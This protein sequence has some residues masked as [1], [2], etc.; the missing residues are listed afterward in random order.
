MVNQE[1]V[2]VMVKAIQDDDFDVE[3]GE[4]IPTIEL[5]AHSDQTYDEDHTLQNPGDENDT[6]AASSVDQ[7]SRRSLATAAVASPIGGIMSRS[8]QAVEGS[9]PRRRPEFISAA[10]IKP[11]PETE[12]GLS[13][14]MRESGRGIEI[15]S[16]S[17]SGLMAE[18][19]APVKVGDK[20]VSVND[21]SC[22]RMDYKHA[23]KLLREAEGR[24]TLVVH[25]IGGDSRLVES[26]IAKPAPNH[27]T[28]IGFSST[29]SP[30]QLHISRIFVDGLFANSLL[31][32]GD[33]VLYINSIPCREL[34]SATAADIV[35][36]TPEYITIVTRKF[37]GNGVVI[38][39]NDTE[40]QQLNEAARLAKYGM[41]KQIFCFFVFLVTM[42]VLIMYLQ[43]Y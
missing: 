16:I 38:A 22:D 20:I 1:E 25:N 39:S 40:I 42:V 12:L 17:D 24:V 33:E 9:R 5:S 8:E 30:S 14:K 31:T 18:A 19:G 4:D 26:M 36:T 15:S 7:P 35:K 21:Y 10:V 13:F 37:E 32:V 29:E 27:Q 11:S 3:A 23:A 41:R 6:G 2:Q 43:F 28:G 34:D